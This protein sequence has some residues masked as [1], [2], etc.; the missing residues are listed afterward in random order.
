LKKAILVHGFNKNSK[1]MRS[2]SLNLQELGVSCYSVQLPLTFNKIEES[3][4]IFEELFLEYIRKMDTHE[5][6]SLIGHSSGGLVIRK[7]LSDTKHIERIDKCVLIAT[8]SFGTKLADIAGRISKTYIGV[9]K[10]LGSLRTDTI[11]HMKMLERNIEVGAI[12]GNKNNLMLGKLL[13]EE[14]DGRV[15]VRSVYY[16]QLKDFIVVPFG[17]KEIHHQKHTAKLISNFLE[18]GKFIKEDV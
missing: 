15:E 13:D 6:V 4:V 16:D 8:P 9:F 17:H 11:P 18:T 1:D 10:T 12:A 7:F 2:L 3:T 14:N 5:K